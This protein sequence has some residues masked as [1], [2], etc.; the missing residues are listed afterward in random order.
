MSSEGSRRMPKGLMVGGGA[1]LALLAAVMVAH[2]RADS[3]QAPPPASVS[4][5]PAPAQAPPPAAAGEPPAQSGA[6]AEPD[7]AGLTFMDVRGAQLPVS[8]VHGPKRVTQARAAGFS[9]DTGGAV[10]AAVHLATR[11]SPQLGPEVY[12]PAAERMRGDVEDRTAFLA[13]LDADY[14]KARA[15]SGL[16]EGEPLRIYAQVIGYAVPVAE[17]APER[18]TVHLLSRGAGPDGGEVLV[19]VPVTVSW[20]GGDWALEAPTGGRWPGQPVAGT[21]GHTLFREAR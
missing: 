8:P 7:W 5:P 13:Q 1:L 16:P 2:N 15:A 18:V 19:S 3:G 6:A 12:V 4:A 17:R 9:R 21:G 14:A 10:L 11:V 20:W